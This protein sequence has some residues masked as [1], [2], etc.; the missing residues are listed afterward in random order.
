MQKGN[1]DREVRMVQERN[2]KNAFLSDLMEMLNLMHDGTNNCISFF[3]FDKCLKNQEITRV[4]E[5]IGVCTEDVACLFDLLDVDGDGV[6][7]V[8][9]LVEGLGRLKGVASSLD[10]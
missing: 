8:V 1:N 7:S 5:C 3:Q 9:E 10:A 4:L 6:L 2:R